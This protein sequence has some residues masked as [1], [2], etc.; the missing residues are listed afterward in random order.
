M[1][2][3]LVYSTLRTLVHTK[4]NDIIYIFIDHAFIYIYTITGIHAYINKNRSVVLIYSTLRTHVSYKQRYL[5]NITYI[6]YIYVK[7]LVA[8]KGNTP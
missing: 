5:L 2:I 3:V 7:H 6:Y 8:S 1:A 4:G